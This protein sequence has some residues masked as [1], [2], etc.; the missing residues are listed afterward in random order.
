MYNDF[1]SGKL[2]EKGASLVGFA[3]LSVLPS[4]ISRGFPYGVSIAIALD[5]AI[6][7]RIPSGPHLEY[8]EEY[9]NVSD[10]LNDL[11]EY[12]AS[13]ITEMGFSAFPQSRRTTKQDK[14]YRTTLP[15]KT[16]ARLSG[17]GWIGKSAVLV[18]EQ[19]GGAVRLASVL[20]DMPLQT[21]STILE[22]ECGEC[23]VCTSRCPGKAV[24]GRNWHLGVGRD[25][26]LDPIACKSTVIKRGEPFGL[27]EGTCGMCFAV[28][29]YTQKYISRSSGQRASL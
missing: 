29:P 24:K 27:T 6:V 26:L 1:L 21:A 23:T 7:S 4:D 11:S 16:V 25:E 12:A 28:C 22:S 15:H 14:N 9:G 10:A 13:L 18:T 3:D 17:L 20:T 5:P 2:R 8:Y 19:Y